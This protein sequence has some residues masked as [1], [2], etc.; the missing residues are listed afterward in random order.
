MHFGVDMAS[1]NG[2]K[3]SS[4][5][6]QLKELLKKRIQ[7]GALEPGARIP[8][9]RDLMA[10]YAVSYATVTRALQ[11]LAQEGYVTCLHGSGNRVAEGVRAKLGKPLKLHLIGGL[12]HAGLAIFQELLEASREL[13]IIVEPHEELTHEERAGVI[14]D[15][16]AR[17]RSKDSRDAVTFPY[18]AG[19][20]AHIERV[21]ESNIPYIVMDVPESLPGYSIVLRDH[22]AAARALVERLL[23]LGHRRERMGLLLGVNRT[24]DPYQW[25]RAKILGAAEALSGIDADRAEYDVE[26]TVAAGK[27]ATLKLLARMPDLTALY[28]DNAEKA[29]GA[30]QAI[31]ASQKSVPN[32]VSVVCIN[33]P[34]PDAAGGLALTHAWASPMG[35]GKS[36]ATAIF[37]MLT[38][39]VQCP[40][41]RELQMN[42]EPGAST[43]RARKSWST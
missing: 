2:L 16:I 1:K 8:T 17:A 41:T 6:L 40:V 38:G 11:T 28:C 32:D 14:E 5:Y 7:C 33:V 27:D 23:S 13:G 3:I 9:Q 19:N 26:P 30:V 4:K 35:V 42:F 34:R 10:K 39:K 29:C 24:G 25:D 15:I 37:E 21:R 22:R 12:P 36:A 20:R 31:T 43:N 18:F